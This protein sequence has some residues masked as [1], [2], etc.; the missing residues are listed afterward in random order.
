[1]DVSQD[2]RA[3]CLRYVPVSQ[4]PEAVECQCESSSERSALREKVG[5]AHLERCYLLVTSLY[6]L[7]HGSDDLEE[8]LRAMSKYAISLALV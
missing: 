7:F 2:D 1:M 8:V 3:S 5:H 4:A 6:S